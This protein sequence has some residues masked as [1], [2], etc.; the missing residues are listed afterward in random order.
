MKHRALPQLIVNADQ[1]SFQ[2]KDRQKNLAQALEKELNQ[3]PW[4]K[5]KLPMDHLRTWKRSPRLSSQFMMDSG[6][7]ETQDIIN[8]LDMA[9]R[10]LKEKRAAQLQDNK[11]DDTATHDTSKLRMVSWGLLPQIPGFQSNFCQYVSNDVDH[12]I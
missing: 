2:D 6:V 12:F 7:T 5:E 10:K 3:A 11:E 8:R 4:Q 9:A 1:D